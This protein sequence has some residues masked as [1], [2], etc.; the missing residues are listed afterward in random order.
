MSRQV[1]RLS[2]WMCTQ[3]RVCRQAYSKYGH[4]L[5]H[6]APEGT[7][8]GQGRTMVLS[9]STGG[10]GGH[11]RG[12]EG[13]QFSAAVFW[14]DIPG[15]GKDHGSQPQYSWGDILGVGKDHSSQ[16]LIWRGHTR[17][18]EEPQFSTTVLQV[19]EGHTLGQEMD[20]SSQLQCSGGDILGVGK[21]HSSQPQY[22][23]RDISGVGKEH[24]SQPLIW[25]GHTRGRE[26][27]QFSA[28]DLDGTYQGQGRT[29]VHFSENVTYVCNMV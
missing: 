8:Q 5:S 19:G 13:T 4:H 18:R 3:Y 22:S 25:R 9:H 7:Y 15:V 12:R 2:V 27:P 20:H 1:V 28:T 29:T 17:G 14:R 10:R 26:G 23:G 21:Y 11:T 24:S 6:S 16:P